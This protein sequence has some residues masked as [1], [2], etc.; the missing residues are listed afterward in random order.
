MN[1][2][3]NP[4]PRFPLAPMAGYTDL[5]FRRICASFGASYVVSEMIS[6]MAMVMRDKKTPVLAKI[7][8]GEAPVVLHVPRVVPSA[9]SV[10]PARLVAVTGKT[11]A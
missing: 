9:F 2:N 4:T 10:E 8:E 11:A 3:A 7:A 5:S 1:Q 6:A